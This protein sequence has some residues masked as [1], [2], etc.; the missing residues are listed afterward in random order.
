M[1][2]DRAISPPIPISC[3]SDTEACNVL[4]TTDGVTTL[5]A[6]TVTLRPQEHVRVARVTARLALASITSFSDVTFS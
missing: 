6:A 2:L 3:S 1:F 4:G 5:R